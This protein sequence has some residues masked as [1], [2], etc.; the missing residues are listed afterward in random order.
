MLHYVNA[1]LLYVSLSILDY[2]NHALF[3]VALSDAALFTIAL[4]N[5]ELL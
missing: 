3:D 5:V 1:A 4:L 2:S